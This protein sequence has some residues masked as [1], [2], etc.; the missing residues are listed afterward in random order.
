MIEEIK[1]KIKKGE[2][3]LTL[4]EELLYEIFTMYGNEKVEDSLP[5]IHS[6]FCIIKRKYQNEM[7]DNLLKEA[8]EFFIKNPN[9]EIFIPKIEIKR[10]KSKK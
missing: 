1:E 4:E 10:G 5:Y 9:E 2:A 8:E 7:Q 3:N 6:M